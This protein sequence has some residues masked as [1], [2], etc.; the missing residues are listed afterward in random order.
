[1]PAKPPK[2]NPPTPEELNDLETLKA[3]ID[4]AVADGKITDEELAA[5]KTQ[6]WADGKITPEELELFTSL[7]MDKIRQGELEWEEG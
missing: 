6:A 1:M 4:R 5:M 7:V 2:S 3:I